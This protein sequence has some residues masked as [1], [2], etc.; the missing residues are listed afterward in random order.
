MPAASD[1]TLL[2]RADHR[3]FGSGVP[4]WLGKQPRVLLQAEQLALGDYVLSGR[5]AVERKTSADFAAS[6]LD[7]RLFIQAEALGK[8]FDLVIYLIEGSSLCEACNLHPN[9]IRGALSY[10]S[11]LCGFSVVRSEGPEDTARLIA[12]MA[13]HEQ[14]GLGYEISLHSKRRSVSPRLQ[15]RYLVEDLP[16]IGPRLAE[17]LLGYFGTLRDLFTADEKSLREVPGIG[18]KRAHSIFGLLNRPFAE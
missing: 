3:E 5:V 6:I 9:A 18:A 11:V 15:M 16:G 13:R 1:E 10:L 17:A 12:T 2:I 14:H 8:A 4:E 7:R